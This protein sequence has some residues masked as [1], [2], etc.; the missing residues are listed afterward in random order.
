MSRIKAAVPQQPC[1]VNCKIYEYLCT[2]AACKRNNQIAHGPCTYAIACS[3]KFILYETLDLIIQT[4][5]KLHK[6]VHTINK[7]RTMLRNGFYDICEILGFNG[8]AYFILDIPLSSAKM[9]SC[10]VCYISG[11]CK[12]LW[13]QK[14]TLSYCEHVTKRVELYTHTPP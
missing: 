12:M 6:T 2:I 9:Q 1:N 10:R 3:F 7:R 11:Y 14:N 4:E 8:A 13:P 5:D